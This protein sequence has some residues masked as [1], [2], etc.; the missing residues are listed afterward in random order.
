MN[1]PLESNERALERLEARIANDQC[2]YR[3]SPELGKA[4]REAGPPLLSIKR[5]EGR[6]DVTVD[7]GASDNTVVWFRAFLGSGEAFTHMTVTEARLLANMLL[8]AAGKAERNASPAARDRWNEKLAEAR[9][10]M[11]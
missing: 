5:C 2:G 4:L 1:D 6:F 11:A 8:D 10:G 3:I 9:L 7:T